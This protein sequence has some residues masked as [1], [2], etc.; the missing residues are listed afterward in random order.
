MPP[1]T[2][3]AHSAVVASASDLADRYMASALGTTVT[4]P[5]RSTTA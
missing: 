2:Q 1:T 5:L 4:E 3:A